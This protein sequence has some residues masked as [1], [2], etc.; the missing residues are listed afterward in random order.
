MLYGLLESRWLAD[1]ARTARQAAL[2]SQTLGIRNIWTKLRACCSWPTAKS[3]A[4]AL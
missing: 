3:L 1:N 2:I 4:D